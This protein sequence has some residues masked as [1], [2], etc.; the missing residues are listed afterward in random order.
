MD[1]DQGFPGHNGAAHADF[2]LPEW[3]LQEFWPKQVA[4]WGRIIAGTDLFHS[5]GPFG[6][7]P[8]FL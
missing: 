2:R 3:V 1:F 6:V 4:E 5:Q 8:C 7:G